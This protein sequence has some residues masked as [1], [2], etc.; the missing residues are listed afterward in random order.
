MMKLT[1]FIERSLR[2]IKLREMRPL[3]KIEGVQKHID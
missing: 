1:Q 3:L 2:K